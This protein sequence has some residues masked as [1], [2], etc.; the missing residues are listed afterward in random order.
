[1]SDQVLPA[2]LDGGG[3]GGG[4][5][6]T[7]AQ[8]VT[9]ATDATLSNE[10]VLTAGENVT[11]TDAGAGSTVT[12]T[13]LAGS[14]VLNVVTTSSNTYNFADTDCIVLANPTANQILSLPWAGLHP[15]RVIT[16]KRA[17]A[18]GFT[19]TVSTAGEN[20]DGSITR[21]LSAYESITVV[22]DGTNWWV[23]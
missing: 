1:M 18:N 21:L 2:P 6:P 3:G 20:M 4:G 15:G 22:S 11:L 13:A 9:L 23:I 19:V 12:V 10:R 5:A 17:A 16:I 8:Y 7:S 14:M